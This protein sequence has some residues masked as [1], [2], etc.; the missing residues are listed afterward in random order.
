VTVQ[1]VT[2]AGFFVG[3]SAQDRRFVEWGGD[4]GDDE[5]DQP[6]RPQVGDKVNLTGP[7]KEAPEDPAQTLD[8]PEQDAAL[9][10]EQGAYVNAD[11]VEPA[12]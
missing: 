10:S 9:V 2:E 3:T 1:S 5:A 11:S 12:S 6:F 8:L 4:V 7:V